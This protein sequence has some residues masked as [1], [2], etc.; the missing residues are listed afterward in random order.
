MGMGLS[1]FNDSVKLQFSYGQMT[2]TQFSSLGGTGDVRYGGHILGIKI[3][4][5][6]YTLP[7]SSLLGPDWNWLSGSVTLGANFSLFDLGNQGYTQSGN[8]TWLS[9]MI[10]QVEF[11]KITIPNRKYLRTYSF[12]TEGQL[13]FVPTDM[14]AS[15]FNINTVIPGIVLGLRMYIF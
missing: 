12:F 3:L 2:Q 4:A 13:W 6:I 5:N 7:F 14:N 8:S 15:V 1:F 11:P 9:A 10:T